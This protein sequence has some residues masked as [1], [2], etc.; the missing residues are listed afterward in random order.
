LKLVLAADSGQR[1]NHFEDIFAKIDAIVDELSGKSKNDG[2]NDAAATRPQSLSRRLRAFGAGIVAR[3]CTRAAKRRCEAPPTSEDP[4]RS[5]AESLPDNIARWD[6]SGNYLYVNSTHARTLGRPAAELIGTRIPDSHAAVIASID[7][8]ATTGAPLLGIRQ[9]L[10]D[11]QEGRRVHE[12]S[13]IPERNAQGRIVSVLGIGRDITARVSAQEELESAHTQLV[14]VLRTIPDMVW[15]KNRDGVYLWCNHAFERLTGMR[16]R[17]LVGK[18]D[19]DLFAPA[20]ADFFRERDNAAIQARQICINEERVIYPDT[21]EK[22]L[23]ETRKVPIFDAAG[24]T[25][26]VLGVAR[27][28]TER[29]RF[30]EMLANREQEFRTLVENSPDIVMRYAR[31]YRRLYVNPAFASMLGQPAEALIG[32]NALADMVPSNRILYEEKLSEV[33]ASGNGL[34]FELQWTSKD[35]KPFCFLIR[36]TPEIGADGATETVLATGRDITD[37]HASRQKIHEMAFYDTLTGLPNRALFNDRLKLATTGSSHH[38]TSCV[39]MIDLDHFKGV[40]DTMGHNAGD[41]LLR[42]AAQRLRACVRGDDT[43]ARFGGDEFAVLL[44][45][46]PDVRAVAE[47]ARAIIDQ[48]DG[49]FDLNGKDVFLSCSIGIALCPNDGTEPDDLMKYADLAMYSAKRA[50]RRGFHFYSAKLTHDADARFALESELRLAIERGELE[51]HYQPKVSL[52]DKAVIGSEALLRWRRA[53]HYVPPHEFIPVAEKTGFIDE[54]GRWALHEASRSAVEWNARSASCH[55]VAVNLSARQFR[56]GT[57]ARV[58]SD[59]LEQTGCSPEWLEFE[60]TEGLLLE[61]NESVRNTLAEFKSMGLS[62]AVDDFGTGYSSLSYLARFPIDTLKIDKSFV[63]KVT[64]DRRHAE[65]VKAVISIAQCLG[66]QIVAEGVETLQQAAFL[67]THG[68]GVA[69]GFLYS[70]PRTKCDMASLPR[71][72]DVG[73][74]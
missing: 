58:V 20:L 16:E 8:V 5:L 39:M 60:I 66:L 29:S 6:C 12:V 19:Y 62:I 48:F 22:A 71:H 14:A 13:I 9:E 43:V 57:L 23:L 49:C 65:L 40:N 17:D 38:R 52:H 28:I 55:K 36:L 51:L 1:P 26:G 10:I 25:T 54:I 7:Q 61:E 56:T 2:S 31:D 42:Q 46:V 72:L 3:V 27:D 69:Q 35:G 73:H 18:T 41:D 53:G 37:L 70:K 50:G 30:V 67:A 68:C 74:P 45:D 64:T 44:P 34:E 21:G 15:L 32:K 47:T 24:N 59:V 11:K 4:F 63:Q 33:F